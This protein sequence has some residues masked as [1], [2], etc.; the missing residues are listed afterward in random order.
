MAAEFSLPVLVGGALVDSIS[1]CVIGVFILLLTVLSKQKKRGVILRSGISYIAGVYVT[2]LIGGMTL[3][4]V[5]DISREFVFFSGYLYIAMGALITLF[6]LLEMKDVFWYGRGFSLSI[7][8]RFISYIEGSVRKAAGN[9]KAAFGFGVM[10]TLIELP[11]TGGPYLAVLA[12]M[13]FIPFLSA[14][15]Y[16]LLYNLIFVLPLVAVIYVVYTGMGVK[17]L[18]VWRSANK[19][20]ARALI[21][22]FLIALGGLLFYVINPYTVVYFAAAVAAILAGMYG[23]WRM[24]R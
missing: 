13:S 9:V 24:G 23:L 11:C 12:L 22:L 2:Y 20:K 18:E 19:R 16:L 6:G 4:K 14:F 21:G 5:F 10:T 8:A 3:L 1:P 7:P 15:P 17:S